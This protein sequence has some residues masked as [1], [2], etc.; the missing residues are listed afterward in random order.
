MVEAV[1]FGLRGDGGVVVLLQEP[2]I[3]CEEEEEES[4]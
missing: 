4:A 3:G 1:D 2:W